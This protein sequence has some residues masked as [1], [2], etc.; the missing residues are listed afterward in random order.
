MMTF[1]RLCIHLEHKSPNIYRN[2]RCFENWLHRRTKLSFTLFPPIIVIFVVA[3]EKGV[4]FS[5]TVGLIT[6]YTEVVSENIKQ[7][8]T[9]KFPFLY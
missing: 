8:N 1:L 5:R 2:E 7:W 3:A 9:V 6:F 4:F